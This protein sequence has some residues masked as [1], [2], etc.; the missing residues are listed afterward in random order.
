MLSRL[1]LPEPSTHIPTPGETILVLD[2]LHSLPVTAANIKQ[3]TNCNP[4][5]SRV[6]NMIQQGW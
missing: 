4:I 6:R 5:L 1:P 2:M 3:W